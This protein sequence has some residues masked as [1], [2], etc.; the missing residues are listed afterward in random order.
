MSNVNRGNEP[1]TCSQE[2]VSRSSQGSNSRS[3]TPKDVSAQSATAQDVTERKL[4]S[5]DPE[6]RAQALLDEA[7]EESFPASD[8]IAIPTFE[9]A[10][11]IVKPRESCDISQRSN[12]SRRP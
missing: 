2:D 6:E 7:I 3:V 10:M 5:C 1:Q 9:E 11:E 8:P 12:E 4:N